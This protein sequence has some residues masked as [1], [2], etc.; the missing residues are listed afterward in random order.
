MLSKRRPIEGVTAVDTIVKLTST[1]PTPLSEHLPD[2][3]PEL[4]AIVMRCL[5]KSPDDRWPVAN[6]LREALESYA[7]RIDIDPPT[8][9]D[10]VVTIPRAYEREPEESTDMKPTRLYRRPEA[11]TTVEAATVDD[12]TKVA[13]P[14][15]L[16]RSRPRAGEE[17]GTIEMETEVH[18][19]AIVRAEDLL[20][21]RRRPLARLRTLASVPWMI[22]LVVA[23]IVVSAL[24]LMAL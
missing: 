11:A 1:P 14:T 6:A 21:A 12:A 13:R 18:H 7:T 20:R 24:L 16:P 10:D 22:V 23:C 5:E 15:T 8:E 4:E 9:K 19:A 17:G 2:V 3:D